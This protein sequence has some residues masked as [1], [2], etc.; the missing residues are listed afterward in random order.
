MNLY[1]KYAQ[2]PRPAR[3]VQGPKDLQEPAGA[4][5][6]T[7]ASRDEQ[8]PKQGPA[9]RPAETGR[10]QQ[11]LQGP[12]RKIDRA[13]IKPTYNLFLDRIQSLRICWDI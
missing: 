2:G 9:L 4:H 5:G 10:D 12:T 8:E 3:A 1:S 11:G 6:Y 7:R 13:G